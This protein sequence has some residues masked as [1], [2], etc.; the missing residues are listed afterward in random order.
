MKKL[1]FVSLISLLSSGCATQT[2][3]LSNEGNSA[4]S[5]NKMQAFFVSGIGQEKEID[6][7][8]ICGGADKVS[9]VQ[10][11][12]TFLNGLLGQISYGVYTPRQILVY[13][14]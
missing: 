12:I 2:Y 11:K 3:L 7:A 8:K 6:A 5:Y 4:P 9:K 13:C 1:I 14:K 10:T